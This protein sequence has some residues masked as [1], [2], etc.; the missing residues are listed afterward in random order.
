MAEKLERAIVNFAGGVNTVQA[1]HLLMDQELRRAQWTDITE[2][3]AITKA[4]G[5]TNLGAALGAGS[6]VQ[7]LF[8]LVRKNGLE[9]VLS[10]WG[11]RLYKLIADA[12]AEIPIRL[13]APWAL[14]ATVRASGAAGANLLA[15]TTYYYLVAVVKGGKTASAETPAVQGSTAR[16][17]DLSC[18]GS[19]G[20][21]SY[22]VYRKTGVGG[23]WGRIASGLTHADVTVDGRLETRV[24][25][26]DD[27]LVAPDTAIQPPAGNTTVH[28]VPSGAWVDWQQDAV[29]QDLVYFAGGDGLLWTDGTNAGVLQPDDYDQTYGPNSLMQFGEPIHTCTA[30]SSHSGYN[31]AM[32]NAQEPSKIYYSRLGRW[33]YWP[34]LAVLNADT[35]G[36]VLGAE[37]LYNVLGVV[38]TRGTSSLHG[39]TFTVDSALFDGYWSTISVEAIGSGRSLARVPAQGRDLLVACGNDKNRNV[40]ALYAETAVEAF[41]NA[42]PLANHIRTSVDTQVPSLENVTDWAN[43]VAVYHRGRYIVSFP[44]DAQVWVGYP[45]RRPDGQFAWYGPRD[46]IRI[47]CWAVRQDG[48][49]LAGDALTGQVYVW[50]QGY[51]LPNGTAYKMWAKTKQF[52]QILRAKKLRR[53][54][55]KGKQEAVSSSCVVRV[56][57]D[58]DTREAQNVSFNDAAVIG[59]AE[60]GNT[61]IGYI[62]APLEMTGLR[63]KGR[64]ISYEVEN[65]TTGE[66]VTIYGFYEL[67]SLKKPR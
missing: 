53:C 12:W 31:F 43:A 7:G 47:G 27:G 10:V 23:T 9:T 13:Y 5:L 30:L 58:Y 56:N 42:R 38:T 24:T 3:G 14:S 40:F 15:N 60:V 59:A 25:W 29:N 26:T 44:G 17:T 37:R 57:A 2:E 1:A 34:G 22:E 50:E 35:G 67:Y 48:A 46:G 4:K 61:T 20:A 41:M 19:Y 8:S 36:H 51:A 62:E 39:K 21:T 18:R 49:L 63:T 28:L 64:S 65:Q 54:Y 16:P 32:R 11:Q 33:T 55:V 45:D 66:P 6:G 52:E